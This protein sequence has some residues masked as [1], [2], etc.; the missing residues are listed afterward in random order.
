MTDSCNAMRGCHKGVFV[1]LK[2]TPGLQHLLNVGGCSLHIVANG[3][4]HACVIFEEAITLA[5]S[6]F[7]FFHR[8][9]KHTKAFVAVQHMADTYEH[10]FLRRVETR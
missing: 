6:V 2:E 10:V 3:Q 7:A 9:H 8:S 5:D 4:R 1:R